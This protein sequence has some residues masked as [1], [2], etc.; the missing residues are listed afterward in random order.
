METAA[1]EQHHI[2][3][4]LNL[5]DL[6]NTLQCMNSVNYTAQM[7]TTVSRFL[8]CLERM[9]LLHGLAQIAFWP[10]QRACKRTPI[11]FLCTKPPRKG[12]PF[13]FAV[14]HDRRRGVLDTSFAD[15]PRHLVLQAAPQAA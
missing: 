10:T 12:R 2:G 15:V 3:K 6:S 13:C 9:E 1:A 4:E 5:V 11:Y 14:G 7:T 8:H